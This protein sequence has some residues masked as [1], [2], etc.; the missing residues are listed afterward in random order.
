MEAEDYPES[1]SE[2]QVLQQG[3]NLALCFLGDE[4]RNRMSCVALIISAMALG[5]DLI[6]IGEEDL[7][8]KPKFKVRST[9]N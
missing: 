7:V 6:I 5:K 8:Y 9:A 4:G 2:G 3:I 1:Q